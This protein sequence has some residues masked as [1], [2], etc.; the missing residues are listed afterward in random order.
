MN[1]NLMNF[2]IA[3]GSAF[4]AVLTLITTIIIGRMQIVQNRKIDERDEQRRI[5]SIYADATK[6]ILKY[7][8]F[9]QS[10]YTDE[11]LAH[12]ADIWLLPLCIVAYKY[13]PLYPYR[14]EM[15]REFCSLTEEVQNCI[16]KRYGVD[17][18]SFKTENFY[19]K[20]LNQLKNDIEMSYVDSADLYYDDGKYFER[21]LL[22]HGHKIIPDIQCKADKYYKHLNFFENKH[23]MDMG[24]EDHVTNLLSYE[25]EDNPIGR[26]MQEETNM[27]IPVG[28]DEILMSYL[29]CVVAKFVS[30]NDANKSEYEHIGYVDDFQGERYM[31]D[32][33]LDALYNIF[34]N[35]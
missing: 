18:R 28:D 17:V 10:K 31:E 20:M 21:A 22:N 33:F 19:E 4:V 23:G 35:S 27:G 14:G 11:Q 3:I 12:C 8:S 30:I 1:T 9:S 26:L 29:S 32:A 2:W 6:F 16:L 13:N 7:S 34:I 25:K 5:D 24:Y 15:Y